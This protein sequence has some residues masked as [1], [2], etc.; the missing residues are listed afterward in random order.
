MSQKLIGVAVSGSEVKVDQHLE[1]N[2][3]PSG[4]IGLVR[5]QAEMQI[6]S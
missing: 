4:F 1:K 6:S 5:N 2:V 3:H